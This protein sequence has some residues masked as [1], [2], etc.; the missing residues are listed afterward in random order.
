YARRSRPLHVRRQIHR[1]APAHRRQKILHRRRRQQRPLRH[2]RLA[3]EK[4]PQQQRQS[5]HLGHLLSRI[6]HFRQHD[7]HA[8]RPQSRFATSPHD[9]SLQGRRRLPRGRFHACREFG[10]LRFFPHKTQSR[11]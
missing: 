1:N 3:S 9:R 11:A 7:R 2:H 5:R 6:F 8:S 10:F 4:Y